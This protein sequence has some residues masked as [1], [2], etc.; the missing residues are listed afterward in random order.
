MCLINIDKA[1]VMDCLFLIF[2]RLLSQLEISSLRQFELAFYDLFF[3]LLHHASVFQFQTYTVDAWAV[4][5]SVPKISAV[6]V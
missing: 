3:W 5:L 2:Y 4:N 6:N 1:E